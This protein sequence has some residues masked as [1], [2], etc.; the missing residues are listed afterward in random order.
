M[1]PQ[2]RKSRRIPP[3]V[4]GLHLLRTSRYLIRNSSC[5]TNDCVAADKPSLRV[6]VWELFR[7]QTGDRPYIFQIVGQLTSRT[8]SLENV[9]LCSKCGSDGFISD[10]Y[11]CVRLRFLSL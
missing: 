7:S 6:S 4:S 5:F 3:Q 2:D 11:C 10:K 9:C 1:R 8:Y